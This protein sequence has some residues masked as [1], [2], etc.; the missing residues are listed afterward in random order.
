LRLI[1]RVGQRRKGRDPVKTAQQA[2]QNWLQSA[3]RAAADWQTGVEGYSGDW[4]GATTRQQ[5]VMQQNLNTAINSGAWANGVNAVG[6][7]GWKQRTV[8]K[9]PNFAQG[10]QAGA[11]RQAAA[12]AKIMAALNNIVPNLPARGT[13]EQNKIRSTTLMDALHAQ[14]GQLGA[15]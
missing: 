11:Q 4:A 10:F 3:G 14:R 7:S 12:S 2:A 13:Y 1:A 8:A 9:A 6:T 15:R 5:A